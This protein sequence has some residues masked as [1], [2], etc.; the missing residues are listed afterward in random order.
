MEGVFLSPPDLRVSDADR[1]EVADLLTRHYAAGRLTE[2]ELSARVD[3]AYHAA[4]E[5]QLSALTR[6]LPDLV[7]PAA[8]R[9]LLTLRR[10]A[11]LVAALLAL[12]VLVD[13]LPAEMWVLFV[14]LSLPMLMMLAVVLVP[15]ALA[16]TGLVWLAGVLRGPR[17]RQLAGHRPGLSRR[18][19]RAGRCSR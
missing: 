4:R 8:P 1:E 5:S 2:H 19:G 14:A 17:R 18:P 9:R 6:D 16:L 10:M 12:V 11:F 13:A 15:M 7:V 3:G